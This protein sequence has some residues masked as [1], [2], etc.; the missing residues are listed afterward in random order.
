MIT[1]FLY[2]CEYFLKMYSHKHSLKPLT[3]INRTR[4]K[5]QN[6]KSISNDTNETSKIL[7]D[8]NFLNMLISS[9]SV[10]RMEV[11][12]AN[13]TNILDFSQLEFL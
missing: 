3:I 1:N 5:E 4:N 13:E 7:T 9:D 6:N 2:K 8:S 12:D 11:E 10:P